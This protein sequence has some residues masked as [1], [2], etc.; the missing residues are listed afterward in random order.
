MKTLV[1]GANG[2]LGHHLCARLEKD[3]HAITKVDLH[4]CDLTQA[5]SLAQFNGT[6]YDVIYH[7][8]AWTQAGD[9]CLYHTGEQ[10]IINQLINT[11]VLQ[12][13][14][15]AQP[16]AKLV[17]MGSSCCYPD[18]LERREEN[19]LRDLPTESLLTYG[20]TKRMLYVGMTALHKQY[21]HRYLLPVLSTLYG[22]GYHLDGRQMHF[23]FDLIRKIADAKFKGG[24]VALWGDGH[25]SR[26][27]IHVRDVVNAMVRLAAAVDNDIVNIA[28]GREYT[29]RWYAEEICRLVGYDPALIQYDT[30]RYVGAKS[31]F[32]VIDKLQ[33]LLP[34][35]APLDVRAGLKEVVDWYVTA[36]GY[37]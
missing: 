20:M 7:L 27:L 10:W 11:H 26:E 6:A 9:F 16:Q 21:G 4:N 12:W 32:L 5:G 14:H 1:T 18:H 3:G 35:F 13:W 15:E 37:R 31:K 36:R 24:S 33:R 28:S 22:S 19:F 30:T 2:F 8:A 23:I 29:I 17:A 34:D 25:Q